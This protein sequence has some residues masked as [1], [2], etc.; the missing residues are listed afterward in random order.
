MAVLL[1]AAGWLISIGRTNEGAMLL[2]V[3]FILALVSL[4]CMETKK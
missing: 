1:V 3:G 2:F 4:G